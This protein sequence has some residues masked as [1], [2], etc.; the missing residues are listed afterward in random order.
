M[1]LCFCKFP[2]ENLRNKPLSKI[3]A[4]FI[5]VCIY[6]HEFYFYF[7]IYLYL[8]WIIS[9]NLSW[10]YWFFSSAVSSPFLSLLKFIILYIS[11]SFLKSIGS[12]LDILF[13]CIFFF[14]FF[15]SLMSLSL[16]ISII[17]C[18]LLI[19]QI[20]SYVVCFT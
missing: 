7:F 20:V 5:C 3:I 1:I 12:F 19:S 10:I 4:I 13:L 6:A 18:S 16:T 9:I 2:I 11:F 8:L 17:L 14:Q 15:S